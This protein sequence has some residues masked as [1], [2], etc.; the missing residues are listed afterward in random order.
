MEKVAILYF[1]KT[2]YAKRYAEMLAKAT[3]GELFD[4]KKMHNLNAVQN[5]DVIV[6]V[7]SV[8][9]GRLNG[10]HLID[11]NIFDIEKKRKIFVAVG[12]T[13]P[14]EP[15]LAQLTQTNTPFGFEGQIKFFQLRGGMDASK[16]SLMDKMLMR[17]IRKR[18]EQQSSKNVVEE[19]MYQAI[20]NGADYVDEKNIAPV[21]E[22]I[23]HPTPIVKPLAPKEAESYEPEHSA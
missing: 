23:L 4:T 14:L 8:M 2:G 13:P 1:S 18:L 7:A 21:V 10:Y 19:E 16:L 5:F 3:Q 22:E 9:G 15:V 12:L 20:I 11:H 6:F 17:N